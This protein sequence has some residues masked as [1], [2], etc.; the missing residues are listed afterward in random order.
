MKYIYIRKPAKNIFDS[1]HV[2][3]KDPLG[4]NSSMISLPIPH[5]KQFISYSCSISTTL[6]L[7][8]CSAIT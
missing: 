7:Y 6:K 3:D 4:L 5:N 1:I 8:S 2:C